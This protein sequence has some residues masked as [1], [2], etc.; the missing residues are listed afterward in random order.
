MAQRFPNQG[1]S[2]NQNMNQYKG[3]NPQYQNQGMQGTYRNSGNSGSSQFH[4]SNFNP[5]IRQ[6]QFNMP[7]M[8]QRSVNPIQMQQGPGNSQGPIVQHVMIPVPVPVG[9]NISTNFL[10]PQIINSS[11]Q[12]SYTNI[13]SNLISQGFIPQNSNQ[14]TRQVNL[15]NTSGDKHIPD[16][17]NYYIGKD[18][19]SSKSESRSSDRN[20]P[21]RSRSSHHYDDS[22]SRY[23]SDDKMYD[24]RD[25][26]DNCYHKDTCEEKY[27]RHDRHSD[28][29][30]NHE[31][32]FHHKDYS[33]DKKHEHKSERSKHDYNR[34]SSNDKYKTDNRHS[35]H[36]GN[37]EYNKDRYSDDDRYSSSN[38]RNSD[39]TKR[40]DQNSEYL[41]SH[42]IKGYDKSSDIDYN[43]IERSEY[44]RDRYNDDDRLNRYDRHSVSDN[45]DLIDTNRDKDDVERSRDSLL[46]HFDNNRED[47]RNVRHSLDLH[48]DGFNDRRSIHSDRHSDH[49]IRD[50]YRKRK[51]SS[52]TSDISEHVKVKRDYSPVSDRSKP[53]DDIT[54]HVSD[55]GR[56]IESSVNDD[57]DERREAERLVGRRFDDKDDQIDGTEMISDG[58]SITDDIVRHGS[59]HGRRSS[60]EYRSIS[61]EPPEYRQSGEHFTKSRRSNHSPS[62]SYHS[63]HSDDKFVSHD[64]DNSSFDGGHKNLKSS[65][66]GHSAESIPL[67]RKLYVQGYPMKIADVCQEHNKTGCKRT[68]CFL[69]HICRFYLFNRCKFGNQCKKFHDVLS[70]QP[71][72]VLNNM[73]PGL[74]RSNIK[75]NDIEEVLRFRLYNT[76][77]DRIDNVVRKKSLS[78]IRL[79]ETEPEM[80][81]DPSFDARNYAEDGF[82]TKNNENV[83]E[84]VVPPSETTDKQS[85]NSKIDD[86]TSDTVV[87]GEK[88]EGDK[89]V[90]IES[91]ESND[92]KKSKDDNEDQSAK[93]K[94]SD[95]TETRVDLSPVSG[96][97]DDWERYEK[98]E[99]VSD[100]NMSEKGDNEVVELESVSSDESEVEEV[101]HSCAID[102]FPAPTPENIAV[103]IGMN[104]PLVFNRPLK[105]NPSS[106]VGP[107]NRPPPSFPINNNAPLFPV[108]Q[109]NQNVVLPPQPVLFPGVA[110][111]PIQN[112]LPSPELLSKVIQ[113]LPKFTVYPP[114]NVNTFKNDT[115]PVANQNTLSKKSI[116]EKSTKDPELKEPIKKLWT[117][118]HKSVIT[119]S[120]IEF[121]TE[122]TA[123]KDEFI[124]EVVKILVTLELPYV[125]MKKLLSVIKEKVQIHVKSEVDLRKILDMYP[126]NFKIV[127]S[128][129]S[130]NESDGSDTKK[131]I[132]IKAN[133][134]LGFC[135]KHGFL[136]FAI[137]KCDCRALHMC[138]FYFLNDCTTK[139]CKFGHKLKTEHNI[140]VLRH[141]RLHRLTGEEL[142]DFMS[143]IDN[144]NKDTI[145]SICK[146]YI[147]EKG[148]YKGDNTDYESTCHSLHL[149]SY[150]LRGKCLTRECDKAHSIFNKQPLSL[151]KKFGLDPHELGTEKVFLM[152]NAR[153]LLGAKDSSNKSDAKKSTLTVSEKDVGSTPIVR[154][155]TKTVTSHFVKNYNNPAVCKFYN[156]ETGCRRKDWGSAGKCFFLHICQYYLKGECKFGEKCKR[157]HDFYTGQAAE[158]LEKFE[159]DLDNMSSL[160]IIDRLNN[161]YRVA[162]SSESNIEGYISSSM[163]EHEKGGTSSDYNIGETNTSKQNTGRVNITLDAEAD[164]KEVK[165]SG[166]DTR[167]TSSL[168]TR[169]RRSANQNIGNYE[170]CNVEDVIK[171]IIEQNNAKK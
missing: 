101:M 71:F 25:S 1:F 98:Y 62:H 54:I 104:D 7:I 86:K 8:A 26:P 79:K 81:V 102:D 129:D 111:V 93:R 61:R 55:R 168:S 96:D 59:N 31:S 113:Q 139:F 45:Y 138:K 46:I 80:E 150:V 50:D 170:S 126:E 117:F 73:N 131:I 94:Y 72:S 85:N 134:R 122:T 133:I 37:Y 19:K 10:Q 84:K 141:H 60:R 136:P 63:R 32:S 17:L 160:D 97:E 130:D 52:A 11:G 123:Y 24:S 87:K 43:D 77:K 145:P 169:G 165:K 20:S 36:S 44:K 140:H 137:G 108:L 135:E 35:G 64:R 58:G 33:Y 115:N 92:D 42:G 91:K 112:H 15:P 47:I 161:V 30:Y 167:Q 83:N 12:P 41:R 125:T 146:Y 22:R 57:D 76:P 82:K 48:H 162:G 6:T 27:D 105:N 16:D 119:M 107:L 28:R 127:E 110:P 69:L 143:D 51:H 158:I 159:F 95:K 171:H 114:E 88:S 40:S 166:T 21:E 53:H 99:T 38:D 116:V 75:A 9:S 132:Q 121:V 156:N 29:S 120:V 147:R 118:P 89:K 106:Y 124:A 66:T 152:L 157:S 65:M 153:A 5:N 18:R 68:N 142:V 2:R 3:H 90:D 39:R 4:G 67:R 154:T 164:R 155:A 151:L 56:W 34:H 103:P 144:R 13:N 128:T 49:Y 100:D 74:D 163:K 149:C 14:F 70:G 109:P 23:K 148:C 78:P